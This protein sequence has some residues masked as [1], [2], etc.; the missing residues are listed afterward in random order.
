MS[1]FTIFIGENCHDCQKVLN[2]ILKN[3]WNITV[4]N[5]DKDGVQL[6]LDL[7]V[8]PALVHNSGDLKA[9]G[10]DILEYLTKIKQP[11][12]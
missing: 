5:I 1:D 4:V 6:P 10:V 7:F 12:I 3:G 8:L 9:Y 2:G 11:I